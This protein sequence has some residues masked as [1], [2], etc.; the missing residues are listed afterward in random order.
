VSSPVL[1]YS[2]RTQESCLTVRTKYVR[3]HLSFSTPSFYCP[4]LTSFEMCAMPS[5]DTCQSQG[6]LKQR[7]FL[8][9]SL[10]SGGT[11]YRACEIIRCFDWR[12]Q[13]IGNLLHLELQVT[14]PPQCMMHEPRGCFCFEVI[15]H[16]AIRWFIMHNGRPW[17]C[18]SATH[19]W[20][21]G[22]SFD[23]GNPMSSSWR[24]LYVFYYWWLELDVYCLRLC[25]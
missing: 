23:F 19:A 10:S 9:V 2:P 13:V 16:I 25:T 3:I 17:T 20:H 15:S 12:F 7:M 8:C 1:E 6:F 4:P 22:A 14:H 18:S 11:Y 24:L 21:A 5:I